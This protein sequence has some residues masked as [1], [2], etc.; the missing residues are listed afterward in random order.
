MHEAGT[1]RE[2]GRRGRGE[3]RNGTCSILR[4]LGGSSLALYAY[5]LPSRFVTQAFEPIP[6]TRWRHDNVQAIVTA[7]APSPGLPK[8]ITQDHP[9]RAIRKEEFLQQTNKSDAME[10]EG[11]IAQVPMKTLLNEFLP[12]PDIPPSPDSPIYLFDRGT[13]RQE[14]GV[15]DELVSCLGYA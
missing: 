14:L 10:L 1:T 11:K 15:Y 5:H 12:G 6:F 13:F 7:Q 8:N 2:R 9:G 4:R 3:K